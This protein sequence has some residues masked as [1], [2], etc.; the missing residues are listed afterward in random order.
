MFS[1]H[2]LLLYNNP[3]PILPLP[4]PSAPL[5]LLASPIGQRVAAGIAA[6]PDELLPACPDEAVSLEEFLV[7]PQPC[8]V[9]VVRLRPEHLFQVHEVDVGFAALLPD[10]VEES[11]AEADER[12]FSFLF[13]HVGY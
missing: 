13:S 8:L 10:F 6:T 4:S 12:V 1:P 11:A 3:C 2:Y 9:L 5:E 7:V